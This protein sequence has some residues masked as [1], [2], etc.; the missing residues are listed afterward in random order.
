MM[1]KTCGNC[2]YA[3]ICKKVVGSWFSPQN[4]AYCGAY[5]D[6]TNFVEVVR[7]KD[8][9]FFIEPTATDGLC[10][11]DGASRIIWRNDDFCSYGE[12]RE[13]E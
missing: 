5:K 12:R 11:L 13:G 2:V 9:K 8:C 6:S 7:C 4:I 1:A 10:E 3:K